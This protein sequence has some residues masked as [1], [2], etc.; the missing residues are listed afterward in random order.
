MSALSQ[1][2]NDFRSAAATEREKGTYFEEL[3]IAYLRNEPSYRDLY[4]DVWTY[5]DW[6]KSQGLDAR[7]TGIDLVA[8]TAGTNEYHAIQCKLYADDYVLKKEDIDSFFTASGKKTFTQQITGPSMR[9]THCA[10]S[11]RL[12]AKSTC[13]I[14]KTA[15]ST[16]ASFR[17]RRKPYSSRRNLYGITSVVL[18]TP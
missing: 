3:V 2:L 1:V 15:K 17:Q 8:K 14:W 10:I 18:S 6:A 16:G 9:K 4:S 11:S 13:T 12:S 5:A 7:D